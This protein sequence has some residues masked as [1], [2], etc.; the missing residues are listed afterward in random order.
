MPEGDALSV[1]GD[2]SGVGECD[3]VGV[4][5]EVLEYGF[6]SGERCFDMD[7]PVEVAQGCEVGCE[8]FVIGEC[9]MVSEEVETR[10]GLAQLLEQ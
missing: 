6:G 7:V 2:E 10:V 1:V 3:A 5:A 9:L 4:A 8:C